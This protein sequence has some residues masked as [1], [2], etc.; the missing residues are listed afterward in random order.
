MTTV[1]RLKKIEAQQTEGLAA[2][3]MMMPAD[4]VPGQYLL[5]LAKTRSLIADLEREVLAEIDGWTDV[6]Q[7]EFDLGEEWMVLI[8]NESKGDDT[9]IP[10]HVTI[11]R[12]A[13]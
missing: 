12:R 6:V 13:P 11:T 4:K 5:A 2:L 10:V 7:R 9:L 8:C 3:T 1:E